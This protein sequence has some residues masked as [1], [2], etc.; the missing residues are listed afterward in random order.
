MASLL[1]SRKRVR[2]PD[3][4][5]SYPFGPGG[6]AKVALERLWQGTL[7]RSFGS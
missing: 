5:W 6:L 1:D 3:P 2:E 7:G 4:W